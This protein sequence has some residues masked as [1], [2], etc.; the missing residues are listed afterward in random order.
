M[1]T[2]QRLKELLHYDPETGLFTWLA[3]TSSQSRIN[4]GDVAGTMHTKG[5]RAI[6][7]D[8][9][10]YKAHRLTFLYMTGKFPEN[11]TDHING[12]R[13]DNRWIN[14]RPCTKAENNQNKSP[15]KGSSSK[16]LG[17]HWEKQRKKWRADI[18]INGKQ[19]FLGR[20][21]TEEAAYQAYCEAK[22][23][24]HTFNPAPR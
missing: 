21:E 12:I 20:F 23:N 13:D 11:D 17:V 10:L 18:M 1:L 22:S 19:K 7:I 9:K 6:M 24:I 8:K 3:K 4:I 16:Y 15:Y 5:Y 14:L 2:Q